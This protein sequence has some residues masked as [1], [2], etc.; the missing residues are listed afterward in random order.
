MLMIPLYA[1][2]ESTGEPNC[3]MI[4][5][6]LIDRT[7]LHEAFIYYYTLLRD[8]GRPELDK[9]LFSKVN[10]VFNRL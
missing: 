9:A 4:F 1:S 5:P 7:K 3:F 6:Q 10:N 8:W 2:V